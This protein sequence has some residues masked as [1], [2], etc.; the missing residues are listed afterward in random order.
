MVRP[1]FV[2][3]SVIVALIVSGLSPLALAREKP[4]PR[5]KQ[6]SGQV[7]GDL[8][9]GGITFA[10]GLTGSLPFA[11]IAGILGKYVATYGVQ[12]VRNLIDAIKGYPPQTLG[13]VNIA[14]I[15]LI[16]VKR[17]LYSTLISI[18]K[19]AEDRP[20]E[21]S[22]AKELDDL[23]KDVTTLCEK[24]A[25]NPTTIDDSL[26][27]YSFLQ[28]AIDAKQSLDVNKWLSVGEM[29]NTY[30]YLLLLYLDVLMTEQTL[31]QTQNLVVGT[32]IQ[33]AVSAISKNVY[34]SAAEKEYQAQMVMNIGLRWHKMLDD[35]HVMLARVLKKPL[36]DLEAENKA[37]EDEINEEK[38]KN[39]QHNDAQREQEQSEEA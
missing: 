22:L 18:R 8:V 39:D 37:I 2:I 33:E 28:V 7:A 6:M 13:E 1:R 14:Y 5:W 3:F 24:G 15:Y 12:G 9:Q 4:D 36:E 27:N 16:N 38:K 17:N 11:L 23:E 25:C 30:Q 19:S 20:G 26:V 21:A 34:I 35:R 10:A 32:Q 29:K 31:V